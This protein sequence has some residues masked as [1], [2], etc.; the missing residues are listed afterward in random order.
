MQRTFMGRGSQRTYSTPRHP[1]HV[2]GPATENRVLLR[3]SRVAE[4]FTSQR[5]SKKIEARMREIVAPGR[6]DHSRGL[7]TATPRVAFFDS[8]GE[9]YKAEYIGE[10]PAGEEIQPLPAG[11]FCRSLCRT[12]PAF[13][14][15]SSAR[16]SS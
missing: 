6:E 8:I 7:A 4:P 1:G 5:I 2:S 12:A 15:L 11:R 14:G 3:F 10:I 16:P 13:D 9:R